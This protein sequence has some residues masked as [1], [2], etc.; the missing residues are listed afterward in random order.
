MKPLKLTLS[1]FG[2]YAGTAMVDF[3]KLGE[4][5]IYLITGDTG[6]GK[7]TIFD[8]ITFA[9]YG[10]ASGNNREPSMLR[11]K[12]AL[13]GTP[14]YVELTFRYGGRIYT[15]RR[16]P[17]YLRAKERGE[18]MTS[19]KAEACLI[20]PDGR[21]PVT[22]YKE[23]TKAVTEI[24]GLDRNRFTQIAMIAQGDFLKLL[25]ARTEERISIFREIFNT[26]PYRIFQDALK[27]Q[28][29]KLRN[30]TDSL[31]QSILQ[32]RSGISCGDDSSLKQELDALKRTSSPGIV[33]DILDLLLRILEED[34]SSLGE[35]EAKLLQTEKQADQTAGELERAL[36]KEQWVAQLGK[37]EQEIGGHRERIRQAEEVFSRCEARLPLCDTLAGKI[38]TETGKLAN[39]EEQERLL[40]QKTETEAETARE[41]QKKN[42]AEEAA[43]SLKQRI[44]GAKKELKQLNGSPAKAASLKGQLSELERGIQDLKELSASTE[45]CRQLCREHQAAAQDYKRSYENYQVYKGNFEQMERAFLDEQAGI[46]AAGLR[47]GVPCPVCGSTE[48]PMPAA[49]R[50]DAPT[51]QQLNAAREK[52]ASLEKQVSSLSREA[53]MKKGRADT[54]LASWQDSVRRIF[55]ELPPEKA[56]ESVSSRLSD[57][58][59][60]RKE[61]LSALQKAEKDAARAAEV[62]QAMPKAERKLEQ[63]YQEISE[64]S[65]RLT[66]LSSLLSAVTERLNAISTEYPTKQEALSRIEEMKRQKDT[67]R[68]E[69]DR[70]SAALQKLR[71]ELAAGL[72]A[73]DTLQKQADHTDLPPVSALQERKAL[74]GREKIRLSA[75]K[76]TV[77]VR[78]STNSRAMESIG[79]QGNALAE[80][81][82]K[83]SWVKALADT[84]GGTVSGKDKIMLETYVQMNYFDRILSRA[85]LRLMSMT[86]GQYELVRRKEADSLRSQSGLELDVLDHYNS[87]GRSVKTLSGGES[88][89]ASLCLALGLSDEIQE[90]SGG[91]RLESMFV[92]EGFGSL[93]EESLEQALRVLQNLSEGNRLVGIISHVSELKERIDRKILVKKEKTG[94]SSL[95]VES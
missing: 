51:E 49:L 20:Y 39:Y 59:N 14:T 56:Q 9:L 40:K 80:A 90:S 71:Q 29:S 12:Y 95:R 70:A 82:K 48:H 41:Q 50:T 18:G 37:L 65:Q 52:L 72:A 53:G 24:I 87:T 78:V 74:L 21:P 11:S 25:L 62:E 31:T 6:A 94:G 93:D 15:V 2:P 43:A 91:I 5:G 89:Q 17:D 84:A 64:Q 34:K 73:R 54:A 79:T 92:D 33:Q 22:K 16:N 36:Q 83:L 81:E 38:D 30:E 75:E 1:A 4:G 23:V 63:S 61:L 45:T 7:T 88:F 19:Q 46:L 32:Y 68:A 66:E 69:Y 8:A 58:E 60:Q 44:A 55:G 86:G 28:V 26:T 42:R 13:P 85:N 3:E 77:T 10:E 67:I 47:P 57:L 27:D 76:D 35:I